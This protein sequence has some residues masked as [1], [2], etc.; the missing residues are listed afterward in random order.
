MFKVYI[1]DDEEIV[2]KGLKKIIDWKAIGF[3]ICGEAGDGATAYND[4]QLLQ[5]DLIVLDI[6]M[7]KLHGLDLAKKLREEGYLGRIIILSGYSE[8]KY[9]QD[10]IKCD[11]DYYLTKPLDE[12]ELLNA[13]VNIRT[14]IQKKLLHAQHLNYYQENAKH[15]I[16][17]DM[18]VSSETPNLASSVYTLGELN[19]EADRY[20]ILILKALHPEEKNIGEYSQAFIDFCAMMKVPIKT[21]TIELLTIQRVEVV[22]LKGDQIITRFED[23]MK[24]YYED[25]TKSYFI[26]AGRVVIGINEIYFSYH[27]ALAITERHFFYNPNRFIMSYADLPNL[28]SLK[29]QFGSEDSKEYGKKIYE[30][31]QTYNRIACF[32]LLQELEEKIVNAKNSV[33]SIKS[34]LSGLF[35]HIN[36]DFKKDYAHINYEFS[37][38]A[39]IIQYIHTTVYLYE[40]FNFLREQIDFLIKLIG[41]SNSDSI[42]DEI[43]DYITYNYSK[44]IKLKTLAPKFGYNSSYLGKIFHKKVGMSFNDYLHKIRTDNAKTLLL[45]ANY[46]VYEIS[47]LVGYKNVDYFHLKFRFHVGCTPNEYRIQYNI[48][49]DDSELGT[50]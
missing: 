49:V 40:I 15:K 20:Q 22:L 35:L 33:E 25:S 41:N 12:T 19:L 17:Q 34:F 30:S 29:Y 6:R 27:D 39:E 46:K 13:V 23:Y 8:F 37:T 47:T 2:R 5:P 24:E 38:N 1:A 7:P 3:E 21:K 16:L 31:I 10:A 32:K 48:D 36:Q 43:I 9:A 44:D 26:A 11:V 14:L 18:L 50:E 4:I 28:T 45:D 42:V